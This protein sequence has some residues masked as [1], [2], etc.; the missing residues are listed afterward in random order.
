VAQ[1]KCQ[2]CPLHEYQSHEFHRA[3]CS[4]FAPGWSAKQRVG[5]CALKAGASP[6][7]KHKDGWT[8]TCAA[9]KNANAC[10]RVT[11]DLAQSAPRGDGDASS[12]GDTAAL[13]PAA[14][15]APAVCSL[16]RRRII[17]QIYLYMRNLIGGFYGSLRNIS[18]T[19]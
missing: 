12:G 17:G 19:P 9:A 8:R 5:E 14:A 13:A 3:Q 6:A 11:G 15:A 4:K 16:V 7:D 18:D 10:G 1:L 2:E